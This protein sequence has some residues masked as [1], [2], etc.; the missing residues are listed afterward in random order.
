[1]IWG[2]FHASPDDV[3]WGSSQNPDLF[4]KIWFD[5]GGRT[6]VNFFH[7]SVPDIEVYSDY[8]Y[9]GTPDQQGTT[10]MTRR[11]IRQHYQNGQSHT[12]GYTNSLGMTFKRIPAGTFMIGS[13]EDEPGR[14][15]DETLHQ[16]TL[17]QDFHMQT[18]EVIQGQWEVVMG[19]NPSSF[20]N[21]GDDCPVENVSWNDAQDFITR[22]NQR[23]EGTYRLPTE[24][25]WEY[26]ARA[27]T[28]TPFYFGQCLSTDQA[29][30]DGNYSSEGCPQGEYR[31]ETVPV[32]SLASNA[33]GLYDMRGNVWE[34]CGDWSGDYPT[35]SVT[36]PSGS[37]RGNYRV[38][39]GGWSAVSQGRQE[40]EAFAP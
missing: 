9:D 11:Y 39:R 14:D 33:W 20:Q 23:G 32:A 4:V 18:T 27:G 22:M 1:M 8:R 21:C 24:A 40:R 10:T 29:N 34:W 30:Y 26:A 6:D 13:P 3:S 16:V 7:V 31:P 38:G 36:D 5:H 19:E 37:W 17:T 35:G 28:S 2:Y 12:D 25:E 15:S